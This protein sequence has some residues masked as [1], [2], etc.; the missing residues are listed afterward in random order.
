MVQPQ[1]TGVVDG[2]SVTFLDPLWLLEPG[3]DGNSLIGT[4]G[5]PG[6]N[7]LVTLTR[8]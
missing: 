1:C 3:P 8:Q 2:Q 6:Q 4:F 5:S 7:Y